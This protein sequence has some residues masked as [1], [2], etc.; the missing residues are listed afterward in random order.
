MSGAVSRGVAA[1]KKRVRNRARALSA[2]SIQFPV[3]ADRAV[4]VRVELSVFSFSCDEVTRAKTGEARRV[5]SRRNKARVCSA[6]VA[7]P[8]DILAW[9]PSPRPF[10]GP[11]LRKGPVHLIKVGKK[12]VRAV[13]SR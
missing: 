6:S 10:A 7:T 1:P 8:S 2:I 13:A 3:M 4:V 9:I 11:P 5:A 12:S